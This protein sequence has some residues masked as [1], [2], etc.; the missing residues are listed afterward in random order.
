MPDDPN[1]ECEPSAQ[2][3]LFLVHADLVCALGSDSDGADQPQ[4][5]QTDN[6]PNACNPWAIAAEQAA[7]AA[8]KQAQLEAERAALVTRPRGAPKG[9]RRV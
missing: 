5:E 7:R 9:E 8:T 1:Y 2:C 4:P 3:S 6:K